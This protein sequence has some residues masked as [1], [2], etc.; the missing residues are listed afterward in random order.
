[1]NVRYIVCLAAVALLAT[2]GFLA[3]DPP[4]DPISIDAHSP[5]IPL[6]VNPKNPADIYGLV[7][8]A[9]GCDVNPF[10]GPVI[11]VPAPNYGLTAQDE[12][13][14]HSAGER[15]PWA[16]V[17]VYFSG[18]KAS[19][20]I[21]GTEYDIEENN[22]QAAGDRFVTNGFTI[23]SPAGSFAAC[24]PTSI[25]P[26]VFPARPL[27][28]LSV[29]QDQYNEIPSIGASVLNR[30]R[31]LDN[32]DALELQLFDIDGD[33]RP[34]RWTYFTVDKV[35]PSYLGGPSDILATPPGGGGFGLF[36]AAAQIGL[37]NRDNVD[38]I[39]VWD[40]NRNGIA[41]PGEDY[42]V[43]SLDRGSPSLGGS[44]ADLFVSN[45]TGYSCTFLKSTA[46][47]LEPCDNVDAVD[48]EINEVE[49]FEEPPK[50]E[51]VGDVEPVP[52]N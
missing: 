8:G 41:D 43:F 16:P 35:S 10:G 47:G 46:I 37:T 50:E 25:G 30:N 15:D 32:L 3:A 5:S 14:G 21:A 48:V 44:P 1:M 7:G 19:Q 17:A 45:F 2:A 22:L 38:A 23:R 13:D 31:I 11:H 20:G 29:N 26:P 36:A 18:D 33:Y 34:D 49:V 42:V 28:I 12:N 4:P 9:N 24:A 27:N 52:T 39:A 6:C 51:P 40:M